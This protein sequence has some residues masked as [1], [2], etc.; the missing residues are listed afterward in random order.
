MYVP[1]EA[2]GMVSTK[3][4][5][6]RHHPLHPKRGPRMGPKGVH[7]A[8]AEPNVSSKRPKHGM[9]SL[10]ECLLM[11]HTSSDCQRSEG[12]SASVISPIFKRLTRIQVAPNSLC[13]S[14]QLRRGLCQPWGIRS[15]PMLSHF[16]V[17]SSTLRGA[18]SNCSKFHV[19]R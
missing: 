19:V 9:H 3:R 14:I 2:P 16:L 7:G 15:T 17:A 13:L 12:Q 1:Q 4:P 10:G 18:I 11:S 8:P 6:C 5:P